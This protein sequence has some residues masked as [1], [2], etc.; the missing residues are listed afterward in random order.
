MRRLTRALAR[1]DGTSG[2][3]ELPLP[4]LEPELPAFAINDLLDRLER[5][6]R[7]GRKVSIETLQRVAGRRF[8]GPLLFVPGLVI[9]S[10]MSGIPTLPS[11]LGAAIAIM[12]AQIVLGRDQL[13]IPRRLRRLALGPKS[14]LWIIRFMRRPAYV[15]DRLCS[16]R[17]V[18]LTDG[19]PMR[20]AAMACLV[21]A[22]GMPPLE[23]IPLTS[24]IVGA[25][26][27]AF[28]LALTTH[29]G[30]LMLC[31]FIIFT[32]VVLSAGVLIAA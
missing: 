16:P 19:V 12:C 6:G 15:L 20:M 21:L 1:H 11:V 8:S 26:I 5:E 25:V 29:D 22:L 2:C 3:V 31:L 30:L 4:E 27:A 10:P 24:S 9:V 13:W 18:W 32:S 28:G 23:F 7:E 17:L 14:V